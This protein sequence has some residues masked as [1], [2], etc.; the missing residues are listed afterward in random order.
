MHNLNTINLLNNFLESVQI[1]QQALFK[2]TQ[3]TL[4]NTLTISQDSMALL[5]ESII[6][7]TNSISE[8]SNLTF[9]SVCETFLGTVQN[10][11]EITKLV[12]DDV[13]NVFESFFENVSISE[14]KISVSDDDLQ[15][16]SE[17]IDLPLES[18]KLKDKATLNSM[19]WQDFWI[20]I[21]IPIILALL[22]IWQSKYYHDLDTLNSERQQLEESEYQERLIEI[23]KERL[24]VEQEILFNL[25]IISDSLEKLQE[26]QQFP[27]VPLSS[28]ELHLAESPSFQ[29]SAD[30]AKKASD[31]S[32][33]HNESE[34]TD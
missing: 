5:C 15:S 2:V 24:E 32:G 3:S 1:S 28:L 12:N 31:G 10:I 9:Q 17:V 16:I 25:E 7:I 33:T 14:N 8:T 27:E 29:E 30:S 21:L 6:S 22:T 34:A 26:N 19:S 11:S 13:Y 18:L 20:S 23:Q 4:D